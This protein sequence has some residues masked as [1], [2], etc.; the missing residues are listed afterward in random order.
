MDEKSELSMVEIE[1]QLKKQSAKIRQ[2]QDKFL[3]MQDMFLRF[4]QQKVVE[5]GSE[6]SSMS[7]VE[8]YRTDGAE[9][10]V[11]ACAG[12][13]T[14][15]GMPP[16]EFFKSLTSR[17]CNVI[18]VKDFLQ[19]WYQ[20]GLLSLSS[21][22]DE[23]VEVLQGLLPV[24]TKSVRFTGT[25][26]GG[27]AALQ[28]GIRMNADKIMVFGPQTHVIPKTFHRFAGLDSRMHDIDFKSPDID[29]RKTFERFP[30]FSGKIAIHFGK[31]SP[32]DAYYANYLKDYPNVTLCA[33]DF[34]Q[35]HI[36]GYLRETGKLD[37]ILA[38]FV[39]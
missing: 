36:A 18:F 9:T 30:D 21:N 25:S 32:P 10:T 33:H 27:F 1:A 34:D 23:T 3:S 2:L 20:K 8:I 6:F 13:I 31:D 38:D 39:S 19:C 12:L 7:P 37:G 14:R 28:F 4:S 11:I 16:R 17:G 5:A 24:G 26:A 29:T 15:F 22:M 35:H